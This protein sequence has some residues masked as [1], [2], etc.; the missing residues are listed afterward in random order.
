MIFCPEV[1]GRTYIVEND[2]QDMIDNELAALK[3]LN[4]SSKFVMGLHGAFA[5]EKMIFFLTELCPGGELY[6]HLRIKRMVRTQKKC[7]V[8]CCMRC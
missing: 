4:G 8:L 6:G 2:C 3:E 1:Y 5:T 7:P